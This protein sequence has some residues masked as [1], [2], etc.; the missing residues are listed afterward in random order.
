MWELEKTT[1]LKK[2][3]NTGSLVV[4]KSYSIVKLV[5]IAVLVANLK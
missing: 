4:I 1:L 3:I 2:E 5:R